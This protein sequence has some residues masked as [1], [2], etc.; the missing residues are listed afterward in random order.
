[1]KT[2]QEIAEFRVKMNNAL[3]NSDQPEDMK[4]CQGVIRA[5][6]WIVTEAE[7]EEITK[8]KSNDY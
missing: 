6:D 3:I 7:K 4:Y 8:L 1:M 2:E 5:L